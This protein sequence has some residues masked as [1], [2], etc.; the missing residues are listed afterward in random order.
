MDWRGGC[1]ENTRARPACD[2]WRDHEDA[3][4]QEGSRVVQVQVDKYLGAMPSRLGKRGVVARRA[5]CRLH[6]R[7]V[8]EQVLESIRPH[9]VRVIDSP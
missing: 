6:V 3:H 1:G 8:D 9:L 4:I 5:R 7:F 2:P